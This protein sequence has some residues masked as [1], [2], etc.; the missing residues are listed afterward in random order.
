MKQSEREQ[1]FAF[2]NQLYLPNTSCSAD[3][4]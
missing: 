1:R 2:L 3:L 4:Q